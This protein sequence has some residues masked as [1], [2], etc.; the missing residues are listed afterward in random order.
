MRRLNKLLISVAVTA[1]LML[2][3]GP[4]SAATTVKYN[5]VGTA[6][7]ANFQQVSFA[8]VALSESRTELG[9]WN[10]AFSTDLGAIFDGGTFTFKSKVRTFNDTIAGGTFGGFGSPAGNCAK[11]TIPVHAG[12]GGG[13]SFDVT[14]TRYGFLRNGSCIVF[15]STVVGTATLIF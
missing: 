9:V 5:I 2:P 3:T 7:N 4:A 15:F 12:L 13:G 1:G 14:L 8:G 10:A 6:S 11:S